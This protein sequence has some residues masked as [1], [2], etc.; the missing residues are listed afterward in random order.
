[1]TMRVRRIVF[2]CL[3]LSLV[4]GRL[5]LAGPVVLGTGKIAGA[6]GK[7][8][9]VPIVLKGA[10]E[11]KGVRG[12]SLRLNYDPAIL[13]FKSVEQGPNLTRAII[14]EDIDPKADPGKL[15]LGFVCSFKA[16][17]SKELASVDEDG[18]VLNVVFTVNADGQAGQ[19][20]SLVI[21][22]FRVVNTATPP[23]ELLAT[24]ENGEF[25]V[26]GP[27]FPWMWI[28]IGLGVVLLL[29]APRPAG[30]ST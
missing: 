10:K 6:P 2:G 1:M 11:A 5:L 22:N 25:S 19:K 26:V 13:T 20:S 21:D 14:A 4:G 7:D 17:T 8:V 23:W 28:L 12:M 18:V 29:S 3:L 9:V 30:A 27:A 24:S 15:A 16:P